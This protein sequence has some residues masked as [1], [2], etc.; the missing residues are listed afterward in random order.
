MIAPIGLA[1][2]GGASAYFGHH[3]RAIFLSG[4]T[5]AGVQSTN[6][7][8]WAVTGA[9]GSV[10]D[11]KG[12]WIVPAVQGS[13]PST[14][15]FS[16]F[17]IGIDGYSSSSVEQTGTDSDCQAGSPAYYAWFEFY[18]HPS[19]LITTVAVSPGDTISAEVKYVNGKF[20]LHLTDVTTGKSFSKTSKVSAARTSA[21]WIAEAPSSSGG[22]LP[23]ANF[24]TVH[25]GYDA[26]SVAGTGSAT[27][28]GT[29][30]AIGTYST[31]VPITM[32]NKAGTLTKASPSTLT[33][34]GTSFNVTWMSAG[35]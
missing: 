9:R 22:V 15:Q 8:G 4:A 17:W 11:V 29:T 31:A 25:F 19:N 34:D 14:N 28:S 32:V 13:C 27:L 5:H 26:T 12:S 7:A 10:T 23:L 21:E 30:G 33:P 3:Q 2:G 18:P 16:S 6:W 24:G 35:P 1:V 20:T